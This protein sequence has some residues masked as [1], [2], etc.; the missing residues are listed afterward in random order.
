MI[1]SV[2]EQ[3]VKRENTNSGL[4]SAALVSLILYTLGVVLPVGKLLALGYV[5]WNWHGS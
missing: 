5:T 2:V 3:L 4:I 1:P